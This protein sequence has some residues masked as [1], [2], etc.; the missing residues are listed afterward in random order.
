MKPGDIVQLRHSSV[1]FQGLLYP[2]AEIA[3]NMRDTLDEDVM[4]CNSSHS[5]C[6]DDLCVVVDA[7]MF[8]TYIRVLSH[9][10]SG[11]IYARYLKK[12]K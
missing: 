12:C 4:R 11:W 3:V 5:I 6:H 1:Y 7:T 8:M 10:G 9:L 2:T